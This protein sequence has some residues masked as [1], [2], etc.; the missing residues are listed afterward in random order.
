[1]G[2]KICIL[3]IDGGG[4]RGILPGVIV[5]YIEKRLQEKKN[6]PTVRIAN[7]F[8]LIAGTSTGGILSCIYLTPGNNKQAKYSASDAVQLYLDNGEKIFKE[9]FWEKIFNPLGLR[10]AKYSPKNLEKILQKY[11][12]DIKLS[13][14]LKPCLITAYDIFQRKAV[15]FDKVDTEKYPDQTKDFKLRDIARST[16]AAPT[17][18]PPSCIKSGF[19]APYYLVDG[20]MFANNPAMCAYS[21]ARTIDFGT[22]LG[23]SEKPNRPDI[24]D[25]LLISIGTGSEEKPYEYKKAK[26]WG[27][28]GWLQPIINILMSGN[29]ETVDYELSLLFGAHRTDDTKNYY[30]LKPSLGTAKSDMDLASKANMRA[31][32]EAGKRY[33]TENQDELEKIVDLLI[34]NK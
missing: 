17:Y 27:V 13:D 31:L 18:F 25:I 16:S 2:K 22:I 21:E 10:K 12:G 34:I 30:R 8:D 3:S 6:D 19:G 9:S 15:F 14:T 5:E 24:K 1:M 28:V 33:I 29:S 7:Y 23:D 32:Q 26:K 4:I 11:L 20:G